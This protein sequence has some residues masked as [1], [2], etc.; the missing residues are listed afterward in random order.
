MKTIKYN[1]LKLAFFGLIIINGAC[2]KSLT[3]INVSPNSLAETE[4]DIKFVLTGILSETAQIQSSVCYEWVEVS[5]A[6]QYLQRDFTS[7]EENNYQWSPIDFSSY[8]KPLKNS[9]Y[10]YERAE[11]EKEGEVKNY[12]QA[13]SLII[14]SYG[15][16]FLTSVYGDVPYSEAL[17]AE[18]G[19]AAFQP[20]YDNQQDIYQGILADLEKAVELLRTA[21]TISEVADADIVYQGDS[22]KWR[23]FA[24]S[25]RLRIYMRL[26]EKTE[27]DAR[28]GFA[29]IIDSGA[30]IILSNDANATISYVGTADD[31]SWPGGPLNYS[32]RSEY[33]RRKPSSTIVND[34]IE[35]NDPRLTKWVA[36]VDVQL[37]P[38]TENKVEEE[39]GRLKRYVDVDI[40]AINSDGNPEN[41]LNTSL[42]VGLPIALNAPND[43]NLGAS[44]LTDFG[45]AIAALDPN[46]YLAAAANPHTSYLTSMYSEDSNELVKA[47][48]MHAAEIEFLLAEASIRGWIGDDAKSHYEK[49]IELSFEQYEI[50]D[51]DAEAVYDEQ[52]NEL[53]AFDKASYLANANTIYDTA[54]DPLE[55]VIHQKWISL[56]FTY[57]AWFDF[58][59]TGY[60]NLDKNIISGTK[61]QI[62]PVRFIY[63]DP[64]NEGNMVDAVSRLN[65]AENDQWAKMWLL[66]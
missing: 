38:G 66:Q 50:Q 12:Y 53:V 18:E 6:S 28:G 8:Y 17:N 15:Y 55:P 22:Q 1:I 37:V 27:V 34:L 43:F 40:D 33:Y 45:D 52:N 41:D 39:D 32:N 25:L 4:V 31:N 62:T 5:A 60:P 64:N 2:T 13:V 59:R 14:K 19:G 44:T 21:G 26:S 65:P 11:T 24:N 23:Q 16:E 10:I 57:E 61:G 7:Y 20:A 47:V 56:W 29:A 9:D 58:R 36:P 63:S 35:L 46:I 48:F 3:E 54:S 49:G 30:P 42:F 51:G